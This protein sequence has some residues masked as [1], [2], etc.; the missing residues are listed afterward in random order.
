MLL[1]SK[2]QIILC[3]IKVILDYLL[4]DRNHSLK[5]QFMNL[6]LLKKQFAWPLKY[7]LGQTLIAAPDVLK[8]R[9]E[10]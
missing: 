2:S 5:V 8:S 6:K 10:N 3:L 4:C 7:I 9:N 1:I